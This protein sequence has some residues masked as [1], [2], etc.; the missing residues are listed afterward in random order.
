LEKAVLASAEH[1]H[2]LVALHIE[3]AEES[4]PTLLGDGLIHLVDSETDEVI[5][6]TI[7]DRTVDAYK[8]AYAE[9]NEGLRS[10]FVKWGGFYVRATAGA[11]NLRDFFLTT[12][13]STGIVS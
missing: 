2:Q 6:I 9:R 7:D 8:A 11:C 3:A 10:Q 5:D 13:R 1:G 4:D 12:L